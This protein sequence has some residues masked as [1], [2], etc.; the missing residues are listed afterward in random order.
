MRDKEF[1]KA[2]TQ[3]KRMKILKHFTEP[4]ILKHN[5]NTDSFNQMKEKELMTIFNNLYEG[6]NNYTIE[7]V[8]RELMA[9]EVSY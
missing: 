7:D 2:I 1:E 5:I 4:V 8:K 6:N 3:I 9:V